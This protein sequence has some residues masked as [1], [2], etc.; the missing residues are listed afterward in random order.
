MLS[1]K[2]YIRTLLTVS[3]LKNLDCVS[4]LNPELLHD[5]LVSTDFLGMASLPASRSCG[6]NWSAT[7]PVIEALIPDAVSVT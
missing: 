4:Y 2:I 1:I 5:A 7:A 6:R 3:K